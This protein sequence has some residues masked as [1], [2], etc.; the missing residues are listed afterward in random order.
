MEYKAAKV[1]SL[2]NHPT[3]NERWLQDRIIEDPSILGL[4]NIDVRE[5]ERIQPTGGRLDLL[6]SDPDSLTRYEVEIQLGASDEKHIIR[7][8]EYWDV[9]RR[10]YPQ[11]DHVAVLVAEDVTSRFLNVISLFNGFIPIIAIQM[12]A[13]EVGGNL[14]LSSSRVLDVVNL[15]TDEE[16]TA[17]AATDRAYWEAKASTSSLKLAD[18][19]IELA[20]E[21]DPALAPKY[22]K[23]YIGL[24]RNGIADNFISLKPKQKWI[25][26]QPKVPSNPE[27]NQRLDEA[28]LQV[29][30]YERR[31]NHYKIRLSESELNEHVELIREIITMAYAPEEN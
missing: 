29:M 25:I 1:I 20:R 12:Q 8:L 23:Y 13:L 16:D 5:S 7:T 19:L 6:M 24:A 22:N 9:E 27:L 15:G 31:F 17:G 18:K 28:G 14:T 10:R 21:K 4:G 2:K 3:L 30:A 26:F 11:Y